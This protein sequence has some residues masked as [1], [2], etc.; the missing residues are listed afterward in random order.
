MQGHKFDPL[1]FHNSFVS[2]NIDGN[3][4]NLEIERFYV[5]K[6]TIATTLHSLWQHS[7]LQMRC[8]D[9]RATLVSELL[10]YLPSLSGFALIGGCGGFV[11][12]LLEK[13]EDDLHTYPTFIFGSFLV[14]EM[15]I[16]C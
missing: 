6:I 1:L 10:H 11:S 7:A 16:T 3:L 4:D 12:P 14:V 15:E 5:K 2:V 8:K 13:H 9:R